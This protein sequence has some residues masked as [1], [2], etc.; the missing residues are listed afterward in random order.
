MIFDHSFFLQLFERR[1]MQAKGKE[2]DIMQQ[3]NEKV[4]SDEETDCDE[5]SILVK[6]T[7]PWRSEK[8]TNLIRALD[9]R[10]DDKS[11]AVPK[12][13]GKTGPPS[14]R[15]QPTSLPKWA[16]SCSSTSASPVQNQASSSEQRELSSPAQSQLFSPAPSQTSS[17]TQSLTSQPSTPT[18][19]R[20]STRVSHR[21]VS[22]PLPPIHTPLSS[23]VHLS[24]QERDVQCGLSSND[25]FSGESSPGDN[26]D[27]DDEMSC[28]IRAVT[29]VK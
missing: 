28:W 25:S 10:K 7:P 16:V 29:E 2:V 21:R 17:P 26:C 27:S 22:L 11:E 4:M 12:K 14:L 5:P 20:S 13:E 6:R 24:Q 18:L 9:N 23:R 19:V 3:L 1:C 8:L 15:K